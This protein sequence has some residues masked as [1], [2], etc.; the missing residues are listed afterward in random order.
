MAA[1]IAL[2]LYSLREAM[3]KDFEN[4]VKR[5]ADIGYP[6]V[7]T[8]G[9]P[10]TTPAVAGKLFKDL[11]LEV[12]SAHMPLPIGEKKQEVIDTMNVLGCKRIIAGFGPDQFKTGDL[13]KASCAKFNEASA[14]AKA[15][16]MCFGIHN[17]WWEFD[18]QIDGLYP[19][20]ILLAADPSVFAELDVYW[21]ACGGADAAVQV[22]RLKDRAPLLHIK[23]GMVEP[24]QPHTAVGAGALNMPAIIGAADPDVL[25]WVIVEL[26][27]C[28]TDMMEAV[29]ESYRYLV[30]KGLAS[31][32]KPAGCGC[33]CS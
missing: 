32:N 9:F 30:G 19:E 26:D 5:V 27:S 15:N 31:G 14:A 23:D 29:A 3:A 28:A 21:A 1:P 18:H 7:E 17:H 4:I 10:G 24:R 12:C 25:E 8:A 16:G 11:G 6:A 13:I 20:D 2:Q 33:C 22:A